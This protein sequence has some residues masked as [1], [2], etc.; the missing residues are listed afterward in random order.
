MCPGHSVPRAIGAVLGPQ[1]P[2]R[3]SVDASAVL[4][5]SR[6]QPQV[7]KIG[8]LSPQDSGSYLLSRD[9]RQKGGSLKF[10]TPEV[11]NTRPAL[12]T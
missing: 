10:L 1:R 8:S 5:L 12:Y 11:L 4:V 2:D 3:D 7:P 6:A 9:H